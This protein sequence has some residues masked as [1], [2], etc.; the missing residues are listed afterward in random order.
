MSFH[1]GWTGGRC[2]RIGP[3]PNLRFCTRISHHIGLK[4]RCLD[5]AWYHHTNLDNLQIFP[6][7]V[8]IRCQTSARLKFMQEHVFLEQGTGFLHSGL[9]YV[10]TLGSPVASRYSH[11]RRVPRHSFRL[12]FAVG[13]SRVT[14]CLFSCLIQIYQFPRVTTVPA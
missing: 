14:L 12:A 11:T 6:W 7:L 9:L 5:N 8:L 3:F 10:L 4:R 2:N 13:R 1:R